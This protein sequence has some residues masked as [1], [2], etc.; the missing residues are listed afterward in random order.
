EGDLVELRK[1]LELDKL[2][3]GLTGL[4]QIN[5]NGEL[6]PEIKVKYELEYKERKSLLL[7][8]DIIL[9][10]TAH[11]LFRRDISL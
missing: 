4:A 2:L 3:P 1:E 9:K 5:G 10:T 6:P 11:V 8:I 7:D